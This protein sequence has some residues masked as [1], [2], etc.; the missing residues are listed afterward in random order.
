M[1]HTFVPS[2]PIKPGTRADFSRLAR[3][4]IVDLCRSLGDRCAALVA[5]RAQTAEE[6]VAVAF[7]LALLGD[8]LRR[9]DAKAA[10]KASIC[11]S[12]N[13]PVGAASALSHVTG[14]TIDEWHAR[15]TRELE[16]ARFQMAVK[17]WIIS[18]GVL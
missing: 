15:V 10:R 3:F 7:N 2:P 5:E 13:D 17:P 18:A 16:S 9:H 8:D 12:A 14:E 1:S 11:M 4:A 6:W